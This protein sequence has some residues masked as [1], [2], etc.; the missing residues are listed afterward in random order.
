M[1]TYVEL[2]DPYVNVMQNPAQP[3]EG[4]CPVCRGFPAPPYTEDRGCAFNPDYIDVVTPVSYAP[5]LGQ[6]HTAL[7]GYKDNASDAVRRRFTLALASVLWRF[8]VTH[9]RCIA[10][11]ADV[12]RFS[13]VTTVP[14]KTPA[15]DE[16]RPACGTSLAACA[17]TR[18][19]DTSVFSCR[20]ATSRPAATSIRGA[21]A[22]RGC[23]QQP[24]SY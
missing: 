5:G 9:E 11:A 15:R 18:R 13:L 3:G 21:S 8:L 7:R 1:A 17:G 2:S 12:D 19:R 22:P 24:M 16:A 14:S 6:L 4:I 20:Q 10:D 23:S